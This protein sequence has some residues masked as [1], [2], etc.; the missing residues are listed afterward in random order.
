MNKKLSK[1]V[2]GQTC[3][4]SVIN[5][6]NMQVT[7]YPILYNEKSCNLTTQFNRVI[8]NIFSVKN[9]LCLL[10]KK[11]ENTYSKFSSKRA[12]NMKST[13]I[14]VCSPDFETLAELHSSAMK[15]PW[16]PVSIKIALRLCHTWQ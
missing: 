4:N 2:Y 11:P 13:V 14:Q 9:I 10:L 1:L 7:S 16:R 6:I 3:L 5:L 8:L 12:Y 15:L